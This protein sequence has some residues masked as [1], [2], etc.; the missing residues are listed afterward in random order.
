MKNIV[1][2][3]YFSL[4]AF[5]LTMPLVTYAKAQ[6][7]GAEQVSLAKEQLADKIKG[8]W[9]GK[10]IGCTYGGPIEFLFNGT[11]IQD[12]TP[13]LWSKDR[14]KWYYDN[15]PGLYDDLYM[16]IVFVEVLEQLGFE[17]PADSFAVTLANAEFPLWHAN[18]VA[19]YNIQQGIMPPMSGHWINN[20]HADDID[21]QIEADFAGLMSP[22]MPN[23][24]SAFSDKIGHIF[25]Y[26][27]GWYGGVYVGALF[28]MAFVS[29]DIEQ[30]VEKALKTVPVKSDFYQCIKD[31]IEW[32]KK[33][34]DDWKQ[35]WFEC[36]KKWTSEVGCPDGVFT[37]FNIDAKVNSAYVTIGLLYGK[38]DFFQTIDI[39]SRC[40]QDAD[41]NASTAAGVLGTMIGY[42]N[43]PEIWR[44]SLYEVV[45]RP[46]AY[47]DVSL[48]KLC[49]LSL[50]HALKII[51]QEGGKIEQDV[52]IIRTQNPVAVR[53]EKSFENH[54]PVEKKVINTVLKD[55]I[56]FQFEGVGFVQRGYVSCQDV[57]YVAQVEMYLDGK[58]ME[59]AYLPVSFNARR[60]DLFHRYQ[61]PKGFH[62][63]SFKWLNPRQDAEVHFGETIIY[64]DE[65]DKHKL[66]K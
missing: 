47:T 35:T 32:H 23:S 54:F 6:K 42:S 51:E 52:V 21:Y 4:F 12:Y 24:A 66:I 26:G 33:Y 3:C 15:F 57:N 10:T 62:Q 5:A 11:M 18:Q 37:P 46:F 64:S 28:A 50:K 8:G 58:M 53:Y 1:A 22:G 31:V 2:I 13:I 29:D 48:N 56:S 39:A 44:E 19:R 55:P 16:D 40:G 49:D 7:G 36:E 61:L 59:K 45:N 65:P 9:A 38:K 30:I 63:I 27:D 34:P 17:A 14:V 41:C 60:P 43:I 25:T 20:P